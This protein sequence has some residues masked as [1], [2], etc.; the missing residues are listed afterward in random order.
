MQ[1]C[2]TRNWSPTIRPMP[3]CFFMTVRT[4]RFRQKDGAATQS[5]SLP[6]PRSVLNLPLMQTD[7]LQE[8]LPH[9]SLR[10]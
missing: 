6:V 9:V 1:V 5:F 7:N 4:S 8:W 10:M 3:L 2:G